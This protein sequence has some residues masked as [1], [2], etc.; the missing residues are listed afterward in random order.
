MKW[1]GS[2]ES[3]LF[4]LTWTNGNSSGDLFFSPFR[5][6]SDQS[7]IFLFFC[8]SPHSR[9]SSLSSVSSSSSY[10]EMKNWRRCWFG[11]IPRSCRLFEFGTISRKPLLLPFTKI[12]YVY[13]YRKQSVPDSTKITRWDSMNWMLIESCGS[14]S[15][16]LKMIAKGNCLRSSSTSS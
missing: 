2:C 16:V 7:L 1:R 10:I 12:G 6:S 14:S 8:L 5:W 11:A 3:C 4:W 15:F 13:G 9:S